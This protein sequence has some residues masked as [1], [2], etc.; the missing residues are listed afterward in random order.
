M[1]RRP[2]ILLR[3][4]GIKLF[5][6]YSDKNRRNYE[7][8]TLFNSLHINMVFISWMKLDCVWTTML[9]GYTRRIERITSKYSCRPFKLVKIF[10]LNVGSLSC[11][12]CATCKLGGT[13]GSTWWKNGE[14]LPQNILCL[15]VCAV[16]KCLSQS[17]NGWSINR[18][19]ETWK[20]FL[21]DGGVNW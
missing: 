8:N 15:S 1:A 20:C 7:N 10:I 6:K 13:S 19:F 4:V 2:R 14:N 16:T 21:L 11:G 3:N 9:T 17:H 12:C 5:V 18:S